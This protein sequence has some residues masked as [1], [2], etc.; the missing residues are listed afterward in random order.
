MGNNAKAL[1]G[2]ADGFFGPD[3]FPVKFTYASAFGFL[4]SQVGMNKV[5]LWLDQYYDG[6]SEVHGWGAPFTYPDG[7]PVNEG[8]GTILSGPLST[9]YDNKIRLTPKD[10]NRVGVKRGIKMNTMPTNTLDWMSADFSDCIQ[11]QGPPSRYFEPATQEFWYSTNGGTPFVP[12]DI[13]WMGVLG[14]SGPY[15]VD[16]TLDGTPTNVGGEVDWPFTV[17]HGNYNASAGHFAPDPIKGLAYDHSGDFAP[18]GF[19]HLYSSAVYYNGKLIVKAP[20]ADNR[21]IKC[22]V[23]GPE[24]AVGQKGLVQGGGIRYLDP[25]IDYYTAIEELD[26]YNNKID[27]LEKDGWITVVTHEWYLHNATMK[28]TA[29]VADR[30]YTAPLW[31][32]SSEIN[33]GVLANGATLANLE[34]LISVSQGATKET[35]IADYKK[36]Y[37]KWRLIGTNEVVVDGTYPTEVTNWQAWHLS[38]FP[39]HNRGESHSFEPWLFNKSSNEALQVAYYREP[40]IEDLDDTNNPLLKKIS[41]ANSPFGAVTFGYFHGLTADEAAAFYAI[42]YTAGTPATSIGEAL[43]AADYQGDALV[44]ATVSVDNDDSGTTGYIVHN[45]TLNLP[46]ALN[47]GKYT[48]GASAIDDNIDALCIGALDLRYNFIAFSKGSSTVDTNNNFTTTIQDYISHNDVFPIE[49]GAEYG[50]ALE[51]GLS[52]GPFS[53]HGKSRACLRAFGDSITFLT[54][55]TYILAHT[56]VKNA[57]WEQVN[58]ESYAGVNYLTDIELGNTYKS[59]TVGSSRYVYTR[60]VVDGVHLG[61]ID[62]VAGHYQPYTNSG[63]VNY[64]V[65]L[66]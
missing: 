38:R 33:D 62:T 23:D 51:E 28:N 29:Y 15:G 63:R 45:E 54:N 43:L 16:V 25:L 11:W 55:T 30:V 20:I 35:A 9:A 3:N 10:N 7:K 65:K 58:S 64:S 49:V 39:H 5:Q 44:E 12:G 53:P 50:P 2:Y 18:L 40:I 32:Q 17:S 66:G 31:L 52:E 61:T 41:I 42:T 60:V 34:Q 27:A 26:L 1:T 48:L 37:R 4:I 21:A 36:E 47:A 19:E 13:R 14:E 8:V 22:Q 46:W 6:Q 59:L 56:L 57:Y 24:N